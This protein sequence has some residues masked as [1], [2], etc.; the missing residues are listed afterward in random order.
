MILCVV[1]CMLHVAC[2]LLHIPLA[3]LTDPERESLAKALVVRTFQDSQRIVSQG[4]QGNEFFIIK[5][6][7]AR[8]TRLISETN[9]EV[10]LCFLK[11][12]R[13]Q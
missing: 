2:F 9:K 6:G 4:E 7:T 11:K 5:E 10:E 8:V 12:G 13:D 1:C 3:K